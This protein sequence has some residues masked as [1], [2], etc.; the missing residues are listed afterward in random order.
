MEHVTLANRRL[1]VSTPATRWLMRQ[2]VRAAK[3]HGVGVGAHPSTR[4]CRGSG[5][6]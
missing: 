3:E 6:G 1:R 5:A 2:T 4:T